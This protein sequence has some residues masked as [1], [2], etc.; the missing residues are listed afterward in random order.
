MLRAGVPLDQGLRGL[1][2]TSPKRLEEVATDLANRLESGV[3]LSEAVQLESRLPADLKAILTAGIRCGRTDE[4]LQDLVAVSY[5]LNA[6]RA[7]LL[8]SLI[9]PA[10]LLLA[11]ILLVFCGLFVLVPRLTTL[12]EDLRIP[13][14]FTLELWKQIGWVEIGV[15]AGVSMAIVTVLLNLTCWR[16]SLFQS[17]ESVTGWSRVREDLSVARVARLLSMLT[18][19]L[20]PLPEALSIALLGN[21]TGNWNVRLRSF[22]D[23]ISL[24]ET[25]TQNDLKTCG[26]PLFL[27]WLIESGMQTGTLPDTLSKAAEVYQKKGLNRAAF[28]QRAIPVCLILVIGGGITLLYTMAFSATISQL[29]IILA[30]P[31]Q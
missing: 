16:V 23:R 2:G 22:R 18:K 28:L 3:P 13:L 14:P 4:A 5:A 15:V 9:Y 17:F 19:Y 12:Y 8:R 11:T 27:G 21:E 7:A 29:W 10:F 26:F 24:G 6:S 30:R 25:C 20:V 1:G 31:L